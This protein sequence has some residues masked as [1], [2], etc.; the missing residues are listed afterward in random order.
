[1]N[2]VVIGESQSFQPL[3]PSTN[4]TQKL[5]TIAIA[6]IQSDLNAFGGESKHEY[7]IIVRHREKKY[8]IFEIYPP[9]PHSTLKGQHITKIIEMARWK[10]E[11]K[12]EALY[13]SS[14]HVFFSL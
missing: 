3:V 5:A 2:P 14:W 11:E 6:M 7:L 12:V 9:P 1:M 10:C 13:A 4:P 8:C